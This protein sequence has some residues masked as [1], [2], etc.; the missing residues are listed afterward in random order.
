MFNHNYSVNRKTNSSNKKARRGQRAVYLCALKRTRTSTPLGTWPSTMRV[1]QF[2]HQGNLNLR[3][4]IVKL[5]AG[6][7]GTSV[8]QS[9]F[10]SIWQFLP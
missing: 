10:V 7:A 6:Q 5:N 9:D 2:R 3:H 4:Y 1:C 8:L